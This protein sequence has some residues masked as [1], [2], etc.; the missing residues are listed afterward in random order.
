MHFDCFEIVIEP[1]LKYQ[2][3]FEEICQNRFKRKTDIIDKI[4]ES[5]IEFAYKRP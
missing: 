5:L 1:Q 2:Q 4:Y 3:T